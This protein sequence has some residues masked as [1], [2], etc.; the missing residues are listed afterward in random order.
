MHWVTIAHSSFYLNS[1]TV[2]FVAKAAD[3]VRR[4]QYSMAEALMTYGLPGPKGDAGPGF[5][6][7]ETKIVPLN[8]TQSN[9][10]YGWIGMN[11][12]KY[13]MVW[14]Y[15]YTSVRND[16]I[17]HHFNFLSQPCNDIYYIRAPLS[18]S[19][20]V[21]AEYSWPNERRLNIDVFSISTPSSGYEALFTFWIFG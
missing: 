2:S 16:E 19:G 7:L 14:G 6:L 15:F 17:A 1:K 4:N 20:Y 18:R 12:A 13:I 21:F 10:A 11:P 3:F 5:T 9:D 8:S